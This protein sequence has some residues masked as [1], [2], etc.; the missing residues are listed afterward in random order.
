[1]RTHSPAN[2]RPLVAL[3]AA[4]VSASACGGVDPYVPTV[5]PRPNPPA[6]TQSPELATPTSTGPE[7]PAV[8]PTTPTP[9]C[10]TDACFRREIDETGA[11]VVV[12]AFGRAVY[13]ANAGGWGY[14]FVQTPGAALA[15]R[16]IGEDHPLH[17][18]HAPNIG[19][20]MLSDD[21]YE[22]SSCNWCMCAVDCAFRQTGVIIATSRDQL[23]GTVPLKRYGDGA[24]A[25][26][27]GIDSPEPGWLPN[28]QFHGYVCP[29]D[30]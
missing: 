22:S 15:F 3:F 9:S 2:H 29:P 1:M 19:V 6:L 7:Q 25:Q 24:K 27:E 18:L 16:V 14:D 20:K 8:E 5:R 26:R 30:A 11:C 10:A 21:P 17:L 4:L 12:E 28:G 13:E 23:P